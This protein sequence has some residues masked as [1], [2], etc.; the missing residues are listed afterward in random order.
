MHTAWH[1]IKQVPCCFARSS[2]K[3]EGH[4]C[5][6]F[7]NLNPIRVSLLG[8]SQLSNPS[9]LP[10]YPRNLFVC[11]PL[12]S[13]TLL[14]LNYLT[15]TCQ[16]HTNLFCKLLSYSNG[17]CHQLGENCEILDHKSQKP[18][19]DNSR[20][21]NK[22]MVC[23]AFMP[24][25]L[26]TFHLCLWNCYYSRYS[27]IIIHESIFFREVNILGPCAMFNIKTWPYFYV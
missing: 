13:H 18:V 17:W 2:I 15:F 20:C 4:T 24:Y 26:V 10:C 8:Q 7:D 16:E 19:S 9:D 5:H 23:Y 22:H 14:W 11:L 12:S 1:N 25:F 21:V 6:K 27:A 3:F